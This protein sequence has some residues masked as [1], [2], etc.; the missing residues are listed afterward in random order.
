M[1]DSAIAPQTLF[2]LIVAACLVNGLV[3]PALGPVFALYPLWLPEVIPPVP[4][5][6]FYGASLLVATGTLLLS[7]IPAALA[8][9]VGGVAPDTAMR[10]WLAA[11]AVLA[12]L[13]LL[14]RL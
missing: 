14:P 5:V 7:A 2:T 1:G 8:E 13:G 3:S 12:L 9:R 10:I 11:A 4:E 6:V